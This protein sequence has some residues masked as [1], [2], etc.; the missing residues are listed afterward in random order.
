MSLRQFKEWGD[1]VA[2]IL[3]HPSE[4]ILDYKGR[5]YGYAHALTSLGFDNA[6]KRGLIGDYRRLV[7]GL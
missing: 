6:E 5:E 7:L 4:R 3:A 1:A 2:Y